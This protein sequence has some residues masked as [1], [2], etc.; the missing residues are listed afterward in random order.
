MIDPLTL[1]VLTAAPTVVGLMCNY[2]NEGRYNEK[3]ETQE[4]LDYL[5]HHEHDEVLGSLKAIHGVNVSIKALL[6]KASQDTEKCLQEIANELIQLKDVQTEISGQVD[7]ILD[8]LVRNSKFSLTLDAHEKILK[9]RLADERQNLSQLYA[10]KAKN[11]LQENELLSQ[12]ISTNELVIKDLENRNDNIQEDY[13]NTISLLKCT[14]DDL[15]STGKELNIS[16]DMVSESEAALYKGDTSAAKKLIV[17]VRHEITKKRGLLA[18]E[19]EMEELQLNKTEARNYFISSKINEL[20]LMFQESYSS[21]KS[22][23]SLSPDNIEYLKSAVNLSLILGQPLE[24]IQFSDNLFELNDKSDEQLEPND[25]AKLYNQY[26][27]ANQDLGR[28]DK[29][30]KY[31]QLAFD[32][33]CSDDKHNSDASAYYNNLGGVYH[34]KGDYPNALKNYNQSLIIDIGLYGKQH[35]RVATS[36][37]NLAAAYEDLGK[38]DEAISIYNE[39]LETLLMFYGEGHPNVCTCQNNIAS[40][41]YNLNQHSLALELMETALINLKKCYG[42]VH[43][44]IA[45]TYNNIGECHRVKGSF[46]EA[47]Q[48]YNS[49]LELFNELYAGYH[50]NVSSIYNNLGIVYRE[51]RK[52]TLSI[53]YLDKALEIDIQRFGENHPKVATVL[54][55]IGI[56]HR[57]SGDPVTAILFY[58]RAMKSNVATFGQKHP[59]VANRLHSIGTA[60]FEL[61]KLDEALDFYRK[62]LY[63]RM[64]TIGA[65]HSETISSIQHIKLVENEIEDLG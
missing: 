54:S 49:A 41:L 38:F 16:E 35:P 21:I 55:N 36:Q 37:N 28:N 6:F 63:M 59:L 3:Q 33:S 43:P 17:N 23:V 56:T 50:P 40:L 45:T 12:N 15:N 42:E 51:L 26:G 29:A 46:P 27:R 48:N 31:F 52:Y 65:A 1:S 5:K 20:D 39:A 44:S 25:L 47:I 30:L 9:D 7:L 2:I 8:Q 13:E 19:R 60:Y 14:I 58:K 22:A 57:H 64:E 18:K 24:A 34:T 62:A 61:K 32:V 10:L 53:E 11:I 4:F